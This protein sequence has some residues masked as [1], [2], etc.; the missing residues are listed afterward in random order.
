MH[1]TLSKAFLWYSLHI[2]KI[3]FYTCCITLTALFVERSFIIFSYEPHT[4]GI[5]NNFDYPVIR[6]LAGFSMYPDPSAYPYAVNPY[7]PLFFIVC[8]WLAALLGLHATDT[9]SIYR[10][11]RF[12]SLLAD[13]GT[14]TLLYLLLRTQLKID[15]KTTIVAITLFF[16]I[17]CYLGYTINRSD[18]M[19][20]FFYCATI[21]FLFTS[22]HYTGFVRPLTAALLVTLCILS[23]QNGISLLI[24]VPAWL[25]LEKRANAAWQFIF[26][27]ALLCSGMFLYFEY[28]FTDYSFAAH[29]IHSLRNRIDPRWFYIYVFKLVASTYL[30]LPIAISLMISFKSIADNKDPLLKTL[31]ILF[32]LQFGFST[33]LCLKWG[34]SVGYYNETFLLSL[35]VITAFFSRSP[36]T[37]AA[38]LI[39]RATAY[40]YPALFIFLFHI[41]AQLYFFFINSKTESRDKFSEQ[42]QVSNYIKKAIGTQDKYVMDLSDPDFNFFKNLLYKESAAPNMDAVRCCTLPDKIFDYSGLLQG[43]ENGKILFLIEEKDASK[44]SQWEVNL[45]HYTQDVSFP[46]YTIYRYHSADTAR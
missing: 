9:I 29:I 11:S 37:N 13:A 14:C 19:F 8:K 4:A 26:F 31:G 7:T 15:R 5:D 1:P 17:L 45:Q 38:L 40:A 20:L 25:I 18:A 27:A 32:M 33:A 46:S 23:K 21:F 16:A 22:T 41:I 30:T 36:F 44:K 39:K 35:I 6:S 10:V 34:S 42:V 3:V 28:V 24:L 43:L 2:N 12:I